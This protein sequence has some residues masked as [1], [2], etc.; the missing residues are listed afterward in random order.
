M[1]DIYLKGFKAYLQLERSLSANSI[2]AYIRDVEK[3]VQYL[4]SAGT[5]LPPDQVTLS[6]LQACVQWI[7]NLGMSATSQARIISGIKAFYR[8]LMLEDIIRQDP[9]LLIEAPK[10]RRQLPDVLSFDEIEQIIAQVKAGTP[11]GQRNRAILETMYSCGLRVSEV[12]SLKISQLHFD[13]GFIRVVGKGDKE[14]LVPIGPDAIKYINIYKDE[15]RVH[16]PVKKGQEDILFLNRRGSALTRVMIFLVIKDLTAA[17][18][19]EKQVS[20][21]TFRHSFATHLVEGGADLRAVQEMLG[22]ESITTTEI[23]THLDREFLRDTLQ[24]FHPRF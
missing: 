7:A 2:E 15:V 16:V 10:T 9:T 12:V 17:A 4:Q 6:E 20:P 11:E 22:H 21:H 19:I 23:Y 24:R 1:W 13:A 8:Y 14:R 18:G 5:P 3:L